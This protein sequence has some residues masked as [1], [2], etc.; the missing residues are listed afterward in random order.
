M[1]TSA[2]LIGAMSMELDSACMWGDLLGRIKS[3]QPMSYTM[4]HNPSSV[5]PVH[6]PQPMESFPSLVQP[7]KTHFIPEQTTL[8]VLMPFTHAMIDRQ[9]V[10]KAEEDKDAAASN[11]LINCF[12][13]VPP[14]PIDV[15]LKMLDS[16]SR[17]V[18]LE[19]DS[20]TFL[21]ELSDVRKQYSRFV[22]WSRIHIEVRNAKND[23]IRRTIVVLRLLWNTQI[24]VTFMAFEK[25]PTEMSHHSVI[26]GWLTLLMKQLLQPGQTD[27]K[28]LRSSVE[29]PTQPQA[30]KHDFSDILEAVEQKKLFSNIARAAFAVA[31]SVP[32]LIHTDDST[33]SI[34]HARNLIIANCIRYTL[35]SDA[36]STILKIS[37]E[38]SR[39]AQTIHSEITSGRLREI[40][41]VV[42]SRVYRSEDNIRLEQ[43]FIEFISI[44]GSTKLKFN[45]ASRVH[46]GKSI[47]PAISLSCDYLKVLPSNHAGLNQ[48]ET[49][50]QYCSEVIGPIYKFMLAGRSKLNEK[51]EK[52]ARQYL[53]AFA[54]IVAG[55][56]NMCI[57]VQTVMFMVMVIT[58]SFLN[59]SGSSFLEREDDVVT[60][61]LI[62]QIIKNWTKRSKNRLAF[63][64]DHDEKKRTGSSE[65]IK[66]IDLVNQVAE[67]QMVP[68]ELNEM[69][70]HDC[71]KQLLCVVAA[72]K[73][74]N[75][76]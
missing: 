70:C 48:V 27:K 42:T 22:F 36:I 72:Y 35:M 4:T 61:G 45:V 47:K 20:T 74:L 66:L 53:A 43:E 17:F 76:F 34:N 71:V 5:L 13:Y 25:P 9:T 23:I 59:W 65:P 49:V 14:D 11:C 57:C 60:K 69:T 46:Q 6:Q 73:S 26:I 75:F 56:G 15:E 32:L 31:E 28:T 3:Q 67:K 54:R 16:M 40:D 24:P 55:E 2:P 21:N 58:K 51:N 63:A 29:P 30:D 37:D 1:A 41:V 52:M 44:N 64:C 39:F 19:I 8:T 38:E 33:K 68:R 18:K 10:V 50:I 12:R 62:K 7:V